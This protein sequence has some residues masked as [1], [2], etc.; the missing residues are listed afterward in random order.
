MYKVNV[1]IEA[2]VINRVLEFL[3]TVKTF[4]DYSRTAKNVEKVHL[5]RST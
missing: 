3:R 4:E 1:L 5:Q 2:K